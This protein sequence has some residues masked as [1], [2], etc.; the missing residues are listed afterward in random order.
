MVIYNQRKSQQKIVIK[1]LMVI[2]NFIRQCK[3]YSRYAVCDVRFA[4]W[5]GH[6]GFEIYDEVR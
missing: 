4:T 6:M 1:S 3:A 2:L 5:V